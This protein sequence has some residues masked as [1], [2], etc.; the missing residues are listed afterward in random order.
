MKKLIKGAVSVPALTANNLKEVVRLLKE[1]VDSM[2]GQ[3]DA[4]A[5]AVTYSDLSSLDFSQILAGLPTVGSGTGGGSSGGGDPDYDPTTDTTTPPPPAN[6]VANGGYSIVIL[7]WDP[8]SPVYRNPSYAEIWANTTNSLGGA[9]LIGQS[10]AN[11]FSHLVGTDA[12]RWYW[13]RFVSQANIVGPYNAT[14]GTSASTAIDIPA[15]LLALTNRL[16]SSQL[17]ATLRGRIDLIDGSGPGSVNA[18]ILEES[19]EIMSALSAEASKI[20]TL[21]ARVRNDVGLATRLFWGFDTTVEGWTADEAVIDI[22]DG[23][24]RWNPNDGATNPTLNETLPTGDR[25]LG[26]DAPIVRARIRRSSGTGVWQGALFYSTAGHGYSSSFRKVISQPEVPGD[27]TVVEWDMRELTAGGTDWLDNEIRGLSIHLTEDDTSVWRVDWIAVGQPTTTPTS[28]AIQQE[29]S[30]RASQIGVLNASYSVKV[31]IAGF[32]AG[33]GFAV[34]ANNATPEAKFIIRADQFGIGPPVNYSQETAPSGA[35]A[36]QLWYKPSDN[37]IQRRSGGAWVPYQNPFPFQVRTTTTTED[38]RTIEPGVYMDAAYIVNLQA[39]Y[40]QIGTLISDYIEAAVINAGQITTGSLNVDTV[41]QSSAYTPGVSG[42]RI[43]GNGDV[44]FATGNFRGNIFAT[45]GTIGGA[46]IN[47]TRIQ[48]TNYV[49]NESGWRLDNSSG[50]LFAN[51]ARLRNLLGDRIFDLDATGTDPVL[52]VGTKLEVLAN[53]D[54]TFGGALSAATGTF[55]GQVK[56][57]ADPARSGL[58]MTG[59]G[60]VFNATGTFAIG[61]A[62]R[63]LVFNNTTL[64]LNGDLV[65]TGNIQVGAVSTIKIGENAVTIPAGATGSVSG[66]LGTETAI[67]TTP[68]I[69]TDGQPLYVHFHVAATA[70]GGTSSSVTMRLRIGGAIV[71]TRSATFGPGGGSEV[72][73]EPYFD[74]TPGSSAQTV[75]ITIQGSGAPSVVSASGTVFAIGLKR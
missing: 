67:C 33:Y 32:I 58:E 29:T 2:T 62:T 59:S 69:D 13:V 30:V 35:S 48:S 51:S 6:L 31:D 27:W 47:S 72:F 18:R 4:S 38:G 63:S 36:G 53:G 71:L 28:I 57:G 61:N 55:N 3:R 10:S 44:E 26:S 34:D 46:S 75:Q 22:V 12:T 20:T 25:F 60:A 23:Q 15:T 49:L 54:T 9:T 19:N 39:T 45:G 8:P 24:L 66:V 41:I 7:R 16:T 50:K 21:Q 64:Q 73:T 37:T 68:S 43:D 70:T 74:A 17:D 11:T 65:A 40:A 5:R 56:V 14:G 42:W 1:N 52:K